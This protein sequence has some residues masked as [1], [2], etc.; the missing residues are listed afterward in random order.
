MCVD[1]ARSLMARVES[2]QFAIRQSRRLNTQPTPFFE[3][4]GFHSARQAGMGPSS[5]FTNLQG[6]LKYSGPEI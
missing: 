3:G 1:V 4:G 5:N 2:P 6:V